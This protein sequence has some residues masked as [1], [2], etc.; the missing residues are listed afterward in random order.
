MLIRTFLLKWGWGTPKKSLWHRIW[1]TLYVLQL[2]ALPHKEKQIFRNKSEYVKPRTS[3]YITAEQRDKKLDI[4]KS[5]RLYTHTHIATLE[6]QCH[7][8][9]NAHFELCPQEVCLRPYLPSGVASHVCFLKWPRGGRSVVVLLMRLHRPGR[10]FF[11]SIE[12]LY[13][14]SCD[15]DLLGVRY[16][17]PIWTLKLP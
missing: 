9:K 13:F 12:K 2:T 15:S 1:D 17:Y 6:E 3:W 5:E 14:S 8:S 16:I 11:L 7:N 10:W 4:S